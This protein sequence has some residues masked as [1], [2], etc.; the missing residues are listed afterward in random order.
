MLTVDRSNALGSTVLFTRC[1]CAARTPH[2]LR[3]HSASMAV[4]LHMVMTD[5]MGNLL[6][7]LFIIQQHNPPNPN[8]MTSRTANHS[9]PSSRIATKNVT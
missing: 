9:S 5:S 2:A 8:V 4:D 3:L 1:G 6:E 7:T